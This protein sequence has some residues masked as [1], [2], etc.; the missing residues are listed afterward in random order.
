[1]P[2]PDPMSGVVEAS[3]AELASRCGGIDPA[4]IVVGLALRDGG[5]GLA[6][7][8]EAFDSEVF[9][10]EVGRVLSLW[11]LATEQHEI[12][13]R[14]LTSRAA[15]LGYDQVLRRVPCEDL[16]QTWALQ[17]AGYALLD[18]GVTFTRRLHGPFGPSLRPDMKVRVA[19][20]KDMEEIV[21]AMLDVPWGGRLD[22]DPTYPPA[23][24]RD[25]RARWLR[26]SQQGRADHVLVAEIDGAVAGY[27]TCILDAHTGTGDIELVGTLPPFRR[28]G[29][30]RTVVDH[31][32][33]WFSSRT[34]V[35]TVRTQATN[36]AAAAL[37]ETAG[38]TLHASDLTLRLALTHSEEEVR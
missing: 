27:A 33:A 4:R 2:L 8:R 38:F 25:L 9:G 14:A 21:A 1:M 30:G 26:N 31:A 24:V 34:D 6:F 10:L 36:Y 5:G 35:V 18:V 11:A 17:R 37:Y 3:P 16:A 7:G 20:A 29:V 32:V 19:T 13:L 12:L 22:A 15:R 28:R 23:R